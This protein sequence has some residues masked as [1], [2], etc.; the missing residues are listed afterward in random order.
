MVAA[1]VAVVAVAVAAAAVDVAVILVA[2]VKNAINVT[3]WV[4]LHGNAKKMLIVV[5]DATVIN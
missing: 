4:T 1:A 2:T 5:T 3:K